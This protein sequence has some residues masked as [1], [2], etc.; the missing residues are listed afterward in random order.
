MPQLWEETDGSCQEKPTRADVV[1]VRE[2]RLD[3][4]NNT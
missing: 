3:E 1:Y 4:V 2:L